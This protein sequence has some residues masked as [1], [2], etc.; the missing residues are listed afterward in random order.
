MLRI[1]PLG[2]V[3]RLGNDLAV[4]QIGDLHRLLVRNQI[5]VVLVGDHN[6]LH[7]VG[8]LSRQLRRGRQLVF[9]L[10]AGEHDL[11]VHAFLRA[12]LR[13]FADDVL[14][15]RRHIPA[16]PRLVRRTLVAVH[17]LRAA[18]GQL[19]TRTG[20]VGGGFAERE[21]VTGLLAEI[22]TDLGGALA[23]RHVHHTGD[24]QRVLAVVLQPLEG[25]ERIRLH[26]HG[27]LRARRRD[28]ELTGDI[29]ALVHD[30]IH[31]GSG[32][33]LGVHHV[34]LDA[35]HVR[36]EQVVRLRPIIL[37]RERGGRVDQIRGDDAVD[38]RCDL[39]TVQEHV[40]VGARVVGALRV[41]DRGPLA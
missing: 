14:L 6:V 13:G 41:D 27:S 23:V 10:L 29:R 16:D 2:R 22:L 19:R 15:D 7:I 30:V 9:D 25:L 12:T 11:A 38:H 24:Q 1:I 26:A 33:G 5:L 31:T 40:L 20:P 28:V 21:L 35:L 18:V 37:Q 4:A 3:L 36:V 17:G 8:E 39:V 32:V 34:H